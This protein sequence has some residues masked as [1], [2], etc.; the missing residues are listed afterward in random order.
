MRSFP[1]RVAYIKLVFTVGEGRNIFSHKIER[2]G[3]VC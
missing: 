1:R 3:L 2:Q